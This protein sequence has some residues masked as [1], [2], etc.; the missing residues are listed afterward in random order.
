MSVFAVQP[1]ENVFEKR[2]KGHEQEVDMFLKVVKD[3]LPSS[4]PFESIYYTTVTTFRILD[5]LSTGLY[6]EIRLTTL[7]AGNEGGS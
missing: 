4:I 2:G 5:S 3:G 6:Q 7:N 1:K